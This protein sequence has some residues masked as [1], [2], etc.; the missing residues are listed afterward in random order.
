MSGAVKETFLDRYWQLLVI[1]I[2]LVM[3]AFFALYNPLVPGVPNTT[4]TDP[5]VMVNEPQGG[6]R[7]ATK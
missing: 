1:G 2:G 3:T 6:V 7:P 5:Q 4:H